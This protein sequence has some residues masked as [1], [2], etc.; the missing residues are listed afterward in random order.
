MHVFH[1]R[2]VLGLS[3]THV[4]H[5]RGVPAYLSTS[6]FHSLAAGARESPDTANVQVAVGGSFMVAECWRVSVT[7]LGFLRYKTPIN[8]RTAAIRAKPVLTALGVPITL[9]IYVLLLAESRHF[10]GNLL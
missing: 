4:L 5:T 6:V 9:D 1:R 8:R 2:D 3:S 7:G 10:C